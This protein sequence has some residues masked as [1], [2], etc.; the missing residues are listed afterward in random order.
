MTDSKQP[1][2]GIRV[3]EAGSFITAP[4]AAM[5]LADLGA[6]I[7]KI[8]RPKTGDPFRSFKGGLYS[9]HFRAYNR[10]KRSLSVDITQAGGKALFTRLIERS[11]VLVENFRPG[12]MEHA[13][14]GYEA[15]SA[16][17]PRLIYCSINGFGAN[18]PYRDRPS[19]DTVGQALSGFLSLSV[20][21]ND[22]QL[23]GTAASDA[24]TG[25]Y[26]GYGILGALMM[27]VQSGRGS[28]VEINMLNATMAFIENWFVEY[29][30][31]KT[32]PGIHHKSQVNQSFALACA[33]KK[34]IAIHLSSPPKFWDSL[35]AATAAPQLATDPRFSS[36]EARIKH[37]QDLRLELS[38][39]FVRHP[40]SYWIARLEA[41]DV[42]FAPVYT[43][44]EVPEDPQVKFMGLFQ[45]LTHP[46]EGATRI[47][48][49]PVSYGKDESF[50]A[51]APPTLG[52]HT[53]AILGELGYAP[54]E[55]ARMRADGII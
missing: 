47:V 33:D 5:L 50:Q 20:D 26:A 53:E 17:N 1:L 15:L 49:R 34:L 23:T 35:L 54:A 41:H 4:F 28:R 8:E 46:V 2:A 14:L 13:G 55:I 21:P 43:L 31:T 22:P 45:D 19:Y 40:R 51:T 29:F 16:I 42:P 37:Y 27:R 52:E 24:V 9:P 25:M 38:A 30:L 6:E 39:I 32:A 11:D 10:S 12:W 3:L 48:R 7:I 44:D 36:R 18:G